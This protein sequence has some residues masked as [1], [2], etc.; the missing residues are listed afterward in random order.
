MVGQAAGGDLAAAVLSGLPGVGKTRLAFETMR[1]AQAAGFAIFAGHCDTV[2]RELAFAPFVEAL[3]ASLRE[4]TEGRRRRLAGD[5]P[6]LALLIGG[7][8]IAAPEPLGDPALERARLS[9]GFARLLERLAGE[10]PLAL[11]VD[12]VHAADT[13]SATLLRQLVSGG[14]DGPVLLL[15]T[16]RSDEPAANPLVAELVGAPLHVHYLQVEPL[17]PAAATELAGELLG[18]PLDEGLA[19]LIAH[20]CAGRPLLIHALTRTLLE[21]GSLLTHHGLVSL[22]PGAEL[23]L[24]AGVQ[25]Q[26]RV[27][28]ARAS[29]DEQSL[30]R[31][32]AVAGEA[33]VDVLLR[34][35][36]MTHDRALA[37]L[38]R[39]YERG[40]LA[41]TPA[42]APCTLAHGLLRD[43][44]LADMSPAATQ[45]AHAALVGALRADPEHRLA[46]ADHTL[47][48]GPLV[49]P[50]DALENLRAAASHARQLG[51]TEA[52][53]RYLTAAADIAR[54]S[55]RNEVLLTVLVDLATAWQQLGDVERAAAAWTEAAAAYTGSGDALGAAR[56]TRELAM[57]AW[58][59]GDIAAAREQ[60][61]A[62]ERTLEGVEPS[63]EHAWLLHT[64][65]V[66]GVRLGDV[67]LVRAAARRLR[68]LSGEL[69]LP[70]IA[71]RAH[72][73]E[74]A[75]RYAETDYVAAD[76][77]DRRGLDASLASDEPLL[78]LRAHDQLS[79]VAAAQLDLVAL[80]EHSRA[81]VD[82][83]AK[84][85]SL[86]LAGWPRGRLSVADL[87]TGDW[88]AAL[89]A[90]SE[91]MADVERTGELRGR[92]SLLALR[93]WIL[94][95]HGRLPAAR[96]ALEQARHVGAELR[97]DRN[98]FAIVALSAATLALA[99]DNPAGALEQRPILE[100]LTSG[101][102]PLLGLAALGEAS[103]RIGDIHDGR[104]LAQRVRSVRSCAT[105]APRALAD[106]LDGLADVASGR[107]VQGVQR[108]RSS[109]CRFE[110][111]GLPF[112]AACA[113]LAAARA[114]PDREGAAD[115]GRATLAVF[116][117]LGAPR[118]AEQA[119]SLLQSLGV[120]PARGRARRETGSLLSARELEV[121]RLVATGLS[122]AEVAT[123]L[124]I[125]PRTVS[126]HL[127][128]VYRKLE[129]SSRAGL[130]RYL[131][132]S[133]L[134]D[135]GPAD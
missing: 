21:S 86:S 124:F 69:G 87:L 104:R 23:P 102:L 107:S 5:L 34:A 133:E 103:I 38:D 27:R 17:A 7:L 8:G 131:A 74:G 35:V 96:A 68:V 108:L 127:E 11:L 4:M 62:A 111:L 9:E 63:T 3:G 19:A 51:L 25:A 75:L 52:V 45:S 72:L 10:R 85:G 100:D 110:Q 80:R 118:E 67:E 56:A 32:L 98:I 29:A 95:R 33:E 117:R 58:T 84:L 39:L 97:A 82:L 16:A 78:V 36:D 99:D 70:S 42:S 90:N 43:A 64:R 125:S 81:S 120:S 30:L 83:A 6:Q 15:C 37:A 115:D 89:R 88:D 106:W 54:G 109:S 65:V 94:A 49:D 22:R 24:P 121:S 114:D 91:M 71:A 13:G 123:R 12:D 134:L 73:A 126:T 105:A 40:L 55:G 130:T 66:T 76:E 48:A 119:R 46:L 128:R 1:A 20:R 60:L 57:L 44:A 77:A 129:L 79:V 18:G 61:D 92:V 31:I 50:A 132:D 2:S 59:R 28:F 26:L 14:L 135:E 122:N 101:W 53:A 113:R 41:A 47:A 93:A 116:D 112:Y